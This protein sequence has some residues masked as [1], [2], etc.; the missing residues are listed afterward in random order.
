MK[1]Y[2]EVALKICISVIIF[3]QIFLYDFQKPE[4][5]TVG[6]ENKLS[7][8]KKPEKTLIPNGLC[9]KNKPC[10]LSEKGVNADTSHGLKLQNAFSDKKL[11]KVKSLSQNGTSAGKSPSKTNVT[12]QNGVSSDKKHVMTKLLSHN[13][14]SG[15]KSQGDVL[16]PRG[17]LSGEKTKHLTENNGAYGDKKKMNVLPQNH[18]CSSQSSEKFKLLS[19]NGVCFDK[20]PAKTTT[21]LL[22]NGISAQTKP[23]NTKSLLQNGV[24]NSMEAKKPN[25]VS[26]RPSAS[27]LHSNLKCEFCYQL[28][29]LYVSPKEWNA[30]LLNDLPNHGHFVNWFM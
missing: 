6:S 9:F 24:C 13:G 3:K 30:S 19:Q 18:A 28:H 2:Y 14:V 20:K 21:V 10:V 1:N 22:Q 16:L 5:P 17:G 27:L 26:D 12:L 23:V 4:K 15:D 8:D 7:S 25:H 29:D 11:E